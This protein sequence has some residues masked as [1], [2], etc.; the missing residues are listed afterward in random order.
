MHT[1]YIYG[2]LLA[3]GNLSLYTRNR[4]EVKLE[5]EE[6]DS[7]IIYKI[8][9]DISEG[10][11]S[12]RVRDTNFK[13]NFSCISYSNHQKEFR[14]YLM[15]RGFPAG[16]KSEIA[17]PPTD[18]YSDKEFWRGFIDGDGSIGFTGQGFP[19]VSLIT[20]SEEI[21]KAYTKF[22]KERFGI[23]KVLNKN[24]RDNCYNITVK[25]EDA[26]LVATY[27][28]SNAEIYLDRKYNK[29]LELLSWKRILKKGSGKQ[30]WTDEEIDYITTHNVEDSIKTLGRTEQSIKMKLYR[31]KV[32]AGEE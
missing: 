26:I 25:N 6:K 8:Q 30:S 27:L 16:K 17:C 18:N 15:S 29:Y 4:G 22:L 5:V 21:Y 19:Y 12:K 23:V 7:D 3:D 20:K 32:K 28:Y 11:V 10:E 13:K 1:D 2:L 9:E 14:D 24:K 31:L